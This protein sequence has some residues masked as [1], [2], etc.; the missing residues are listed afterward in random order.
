MFCFSSLPLVNSLLIPCSTVSIPG[1]SSTILQLLVTRSHCCAWLPWNLLKLFRKG[2]LI[3]KQSIYIQDLPQCINRVPP[4]YLF[5]TV[6]HFHPRNGNLAPFLSL[7]LSLHTSPL[8]YWSTS[9]STKVLHLSHSRERWQWCVCRVLEEVLDD[10]R[11]SVEVGVDS[12]ICNQWL[13]G[14]GSYTKVIEQKL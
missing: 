2:E 1:F 5:T 9:L 14:Q 8:P 4:G 12:S 7:V 11:F 10:V 3:Y 13:I 6:F